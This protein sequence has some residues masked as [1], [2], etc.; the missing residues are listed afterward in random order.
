MTW[1]FVV[2]VLFKD[3]ECLPLLKSKVVSSLYLT[4]SRLEVLW[5][6]GQ[7]KIF[8]PEKN[9]VFF[10][11]KHLHKC[12]PIQNQQKIQ[13][14]YDVTRQRQKCQTMGEYC[15]FTYFLSFMQTWVPLLAK[16]EIAC[17]PLLITYY[18]F[19]VLSSC[20]V[21]SHVKMLQSVYA[22]VALLLFR[23]TCRP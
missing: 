20:R 15:N 3:C 9:K 12:R 21:F 11:P 2:L 7:D 16:S 17:F 6:N 14:L 8:R 22:T 13:V 23:S 19:S 5:M 4:P 18:I 1:P 10:L